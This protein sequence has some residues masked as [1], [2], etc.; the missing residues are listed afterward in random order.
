MKLRGTDGTLVQTLSR[1]SK[2]GLTTVKVLEVGEHLLV[3]ENEVV[4]GFDTDG[5]IKFEKA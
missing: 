5:V 4:K 3:R 2:N 1:I